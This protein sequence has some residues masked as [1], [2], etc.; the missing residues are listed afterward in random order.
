MGLF[1]TNSIIHQP[2][3]DDDEDDTEGDPGT[4]VEDGDEEMQGLLLLYHKEQQA[5]ETASTL[6]NTRPAKSPP[7]QGVQS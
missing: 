1:T 4:A 5:F 6:R 2:W 7:S 3:R